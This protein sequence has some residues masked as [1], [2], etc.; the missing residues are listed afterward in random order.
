MQHP[1]STEARW[2]R[3]FHQEW[4][5]DLVRMRDTKVMFI[6]TI[7]SGPCEVDLAGLNIKASIAATNANV[8]VCTCSH[9]PRR[10]FAKVGATRMNT[11]LGE[12]DMARNMQLAGYAP[13]PDPGKRPERSRKLVNA[14]LE[15]PW[16]TLHINA[17]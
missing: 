6:C 5:N 10:N 14:L 2:A 9:D 12:A 16:K 11:A 3:G 8:K 17:N 7:G 1:R 15:K 13:A 4:M